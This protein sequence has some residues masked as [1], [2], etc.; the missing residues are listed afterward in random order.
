MHVK[1]VW[2]MY[3]DELKNQHFVFVFGHSLNSLKQVLLLK[4][5][6]WSSG[7]LTPFWPARVPSFFG[8]CCLLIPFWTRYCFSNWNRG[9]GSGGGQATTVFLCV[10]SV[11]ECF[12]SSVFGDTFVLKNEAVFASTHPRWYYLLDSNLMIHVWIIRAIKWVKI[13]GTMSKDPD[14]GSMLVHRQL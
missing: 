4:A 8:C 11:Q 5:V 1:S 2:L 7:V 13:V 12:Y 9:S 6:K 14:R 3:S 10:F